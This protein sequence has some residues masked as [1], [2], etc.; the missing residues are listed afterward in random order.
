MPSLHTPFLVNAC[1]FSH[2]SE[3]VPS[4]PPAL[5]RHWGPTPL[6][7]QV[8]A[9]SL[10]TT[11]TL[12][13]EQAPRP[14]LCVLLVA[15][16]PALTRILDVGPSSPLCCGACP[17]SPPSSLGLARRCTPE[18]HGDTNQSSFSVPLPPFCKDTVTIPAFVERGDGAPGGLYLPG[19]RHWQGWGQRQGG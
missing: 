14:T 17:P 4:R 3:S 10:F 7:G 5:P 9:H 13:W 16:L 11:S 12:R 18:G 8:I 6:S 2:T 19:L 1:I 15:P